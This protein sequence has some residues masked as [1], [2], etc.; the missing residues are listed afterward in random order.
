MSGGAGI[1]CRILVRDLAEPTTLI[2]GSAIT[3]IIYDI[4][5][6]MSVTEK[7]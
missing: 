1:A 5:S 7:I 2:G 6:T 3:D 4:S